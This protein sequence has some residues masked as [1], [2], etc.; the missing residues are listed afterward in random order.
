MKARA[1]ESAM[2]YGLSCLL[3]GALTVQVGSIGERNS[4]VQ[5]SSQGAV[6]QGLA[7]STVEL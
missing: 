1:N 3:W 7:R 6:T 2:K 4:L 5:C